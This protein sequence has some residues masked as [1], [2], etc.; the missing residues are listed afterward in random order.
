MTGH[1]DLPLRVRHVGPPM[2]ISRGEYDELVADGWPGYVERWL[3]SN[4]F[5]H[6]VVPSALAGPEH[7]SR[8]PE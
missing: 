8:R 2:I 6:D 4:P 3:D 5:A 1:E 7:E